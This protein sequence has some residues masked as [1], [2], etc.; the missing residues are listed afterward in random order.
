MWIPINYRWKNA[1]YIWVRLSIRKNTLIWIPIKKKYLL[2]D[3]KILLLNYNFKLKKL[4][5]FEFQFQRRE[6][7]LHLNSNFK[8]GKILTFELL[9]Q[10]WVTANEKE[11]E[12]GFSFPLASLKLHRH[13]CI[14]LHIILHVSYKYGWKSCV[15]TIETRVKRD[16]K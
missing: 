13:S 2:L 4:L 9:F 14:S 1:T 10:M 12:A 8:E 5:K 11:M 16:V 7:C 6:N 3:V 15:N